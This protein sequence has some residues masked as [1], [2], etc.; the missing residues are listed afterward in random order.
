MPAIDPRNIE[1]MDPM[2]A[3]MLRQQSPAE[4]LRQVSG[5][6][7]MAIQLV[8]GGILSQHPDWSEAQIQAEVE[9]RMLRDA[10]AI[11]QARH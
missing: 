6:H 9:K 11:P 8:R 1:V 2:V 7:A 5:A 3:Q 4:S 10:I